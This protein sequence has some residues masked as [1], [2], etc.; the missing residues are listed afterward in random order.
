M[1]RAERFDGSQTLA[2]QEKSEEVCFMCFSLCICS[3]GVVRAQ[4]WTVWKVL[5]ACLLDMTWKMQCRGRT[6][7]RGCDQVAV[8]V[9]DRWA[10]EREAVTQDRAVCCPWNRAMVVM[11]RVVGLHAKVS[12]QFKAA[13]DS[14]DMKLLNDLLSKVRREGGWLAAGLEANCKVGLS[15]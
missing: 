11:L 9:H 6:T 1:A 14:R 7:C 2:R 8:L 12:E 13:W 5:V 10:L 3:N 4:V 15:I